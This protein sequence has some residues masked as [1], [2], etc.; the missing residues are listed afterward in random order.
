[1]P[2]SPINGPVENLSGVLYLKKLLDLAK[3]SPENAT[4]D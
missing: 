2:G 1:V 3:V 4:N